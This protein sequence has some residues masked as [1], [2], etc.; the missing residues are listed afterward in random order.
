M[1]NKIETINI[2]CT[3]RIEQLNQL[4]NFLCEYRDKFGKYKR[5]NETEEKIFSTLYDLYEKEE[6]KIFETE[7]EVEQFFKNKLGKYWKM[8]VTVHSNN[9]DYV[10]WHVMYLYNFIK[11]NHYFFAVKSSDI[12][13]C[14]NHVFEV[15]DTSFSVDRFLLGN[16]TIEMEEITKEEF[17]HI[18]TKSVSEILDYRLIRLKEYNGDTKYLK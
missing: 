9:H 17:V 4:Y 12:H 14:N 5:M 11:E 8:K 18:A 7:K 13:E 1:D 3:T 6:L 15:K 10:Q 16:T 2:N